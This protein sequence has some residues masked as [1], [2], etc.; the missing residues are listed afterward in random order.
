MTDKAPDINADIC[1]EC[2]EGPF[3]RLAQHMTMKHGDNEGSTPT[4]KGKKGKKGSAFQSDLKDLIESAGAV[5][6][7]TID[8]IDGYLIMNGAEDLAA[9]IDNVARRNP[10][11]REW[12]EKAQAGSVYGGLAIAVLGIV[13]PMLSRRDMVPPLPMFPV[14]QLEAVTDGA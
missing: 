11:L 10:K 7:V 12:I 1:P 2:G 4:P 8:P 14:P 5:V 9:A 13:Y 6:S 3:S